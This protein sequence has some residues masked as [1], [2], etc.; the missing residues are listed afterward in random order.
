M[1]T[2][3]AWKQLFAATWKTYRTRFQS[4]I[5]DINRR[6]EI[7]ES[8]ANAVQ[9]Q[10]LEKSLALA[11]AESKQQ[12]EVHDR[13]NMSFVRDWLAAAIVQEDHEECQRVRIA[14]AGSCEWVLGT[15]A[16]QTWE[17][18]GNDSPLLWIHGIPGAGKIII[19]GLK[20]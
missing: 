16:F 9:F 12:R 15:I 6:K 17:D 18:I 2:Y 8:G 20:I 11:E 3:T 7:I 19:C 1:L 4:I 10:M 14:H 13:E 5:N